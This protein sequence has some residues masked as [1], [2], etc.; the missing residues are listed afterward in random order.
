MKVHRSYIINMS[1]VDN[2]HDNTLLIKGS[3]IPVSKAF[4]ADV[5]RHFNDI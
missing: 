3:Q 1:K 4:W 5:A 2:I